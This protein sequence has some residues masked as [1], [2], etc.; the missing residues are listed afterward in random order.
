MTPKQQQKKRP[1]PEFLCSAAFPKDFPH[2]QGEEF[3]IVGRSNVGKS[4]F[5]NHVLER[6]GLARTS[7]TPGKTSLANFY[8]IDAETIWVDLPGYGYAH[9]SKGEQE[10]WAHLIRT[11]CEKREN[12]AGILW[13]IDI[14]HPGVRAD[15]EARA[16]FA[17]LDVPF[18]PLLTKGDKIPRS[19]TAVQMRTAMTT[20][21]LPEEPVIYS[22]QQH[23]SRERFRER[24]AQ[25][26]QQTSGERP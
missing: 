26:R 21:N 19:R 12:L 3:A 11:Y 2:L 10:R 23:A 15:L 8:R 7:R 17:T 24:F 16:W 5:I 4:S 18:F 20:L 6:Q 9:A 25:W 14:R 22:V 1:G 13:L